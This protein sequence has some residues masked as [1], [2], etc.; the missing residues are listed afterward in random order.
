MGNV[1][2]ASRNRFQLVMADENVRSFD[3]IGQFLW[4][5]RAVFRSR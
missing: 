3:W 2:L 1:E 4:T 5:V